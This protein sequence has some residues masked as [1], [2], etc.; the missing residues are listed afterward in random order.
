MFGTVMEA[1]DYYG[2][3]SITRPVSVT[4]NTSVVT[5]AEEIELFDEIKEIDTFDS[6]P[7][8]KSVDPLVLPPESDDVIVNRR[9]SMGVYGMYSKFI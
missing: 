2:I 7:K 3:Y 8:R 4:H 6:I 1:L 5:A 9:I